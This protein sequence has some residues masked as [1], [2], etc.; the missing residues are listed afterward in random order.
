MRPPKNVS[1]DYN[2][3]EEEEEEHMQDDE[4]GE[5]GADENED[6]DDSWPYVVW[7]RDSNDND[8]FAKILIFFLFDLIYIFHRKGMVE[9]LEFKLF[10][11]Y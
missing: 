1:E 5:E 3:E 7:I 8:Q 6:E 10:A 2:D 4:Q 11:W 9:I